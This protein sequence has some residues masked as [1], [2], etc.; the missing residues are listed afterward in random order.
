MRPPMERKAFF[1]TMAIAQSGQ[2]LK[3]L[4][5]F[6]HFR[7]YTWMKKLTSEERAR[8]IEQAPAPASPPQWGPNLRSPFWFCAAC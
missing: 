5:A 8:P 4:P 1:S 3:C 2:V 7:S 6:V